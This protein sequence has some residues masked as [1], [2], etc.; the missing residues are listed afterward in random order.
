M[1]ILSE[2]TKT[3]R[4]TYSA[5]YDVSNEFFSAWL[6]QEMTYSNA[7]FGTEEGGV[8]G[9]L[10][11]GI[12]L[13]QLEAAQ[14]RKLRHFLTMARCKPGARLLEFGSGWGSMAIEV[15]SSTLDLQ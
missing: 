11:N 5:G 2:L 10:V 1:A 3:P 4:T 9:D 12:A 8:R 14:Q 15:G 6:S 13:G 7:L